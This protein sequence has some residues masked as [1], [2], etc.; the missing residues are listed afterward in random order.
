MKIYYLLRL[1]ALKCDYQDP[2][3]PNL[4]CYHLQK[5]EEDVICSKKERRKLA[6]ASGFEIVES[7]PKKLTKRK[8]SPEPESEIKNGKVLDSGT[9]L[10]NDVVEHFWKEAKLSETFDGKIGPYVIRENEER[11]ENVPPELTLLNVKVD[12]AKLLPLPL[13]IKILDYLENETLLK[14]RQINGSLQM[15]AEIILRRRSIFTHPKTTNKFIATPL[16]FDL[17]PDF[18]AQVTLL[19]PV[20]DPQT[21]LA[22]AAPQTQS[23]TPDDADD[24]DDVDNNTCFRDVLSDVQTR[25]IAIQVRNVYCKPYTR[26]VMVNRLDV[27]RVIHHDSCNLLAVAA[28]PSPIE[29]FSCRTLKKL[30]L[31]LNNRRE[32][33]VRCVHIARRDGVVFTAGHDSVV[34]CWSTANGECTRIFYGHRNSV[35]CLALC[36]SRVAAGSVDGNTKLWNYADRRKCVFTFRD[37]HA[38]SCVALNQYICITGCERGNVRV[39]SALTGAFVKQMNDTESI[40]CVRVNRWL[41][42]SASGHS[43]RMWSTGGKVRTC[44]TQFLH[45][46]KVSQ[47]EVHFFRVITGCRDGKIRVWDVQSGRLLH[48]IYPGAPTTALSPILSFHLAKEW[49][50]VNTEARVVLLNF[51]R[52]AQRVPSNANSAAAATCRRDATTSDNSVNVTLTGHAIRLF[53]SLLTNIKSHPDPNTPPHTSLYHV[54]VEHPSWNLEFAKKMLKSQ[55]QTTP[56]DHRAVPEPFYSIIS[57]LKN[58]APK[59]R[60][61]PKSRSDNRLAD[62][63][64]AKQVTRRAFMM[65]TNDDATIPVSKICRLVKVDEEKTTRSAKCQIKAKKRTKF[66]KPPVYAQLESQQPVRYKRAVKQLFTTTGGECQRAQV[67]MW[68]L[69]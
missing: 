19:V 53:K 13:I 45:P 23:P 28:F 25:G 11:R 22:I 56:T 26:H 12:F 49:I 4:Q 18:V 43:V 63:A 1:Q 38:I 62:P 7:K 64:V 21:C 41:I 61:L 37:D 54:P 44:L 67:H 31:S 69:K 65:R 42:S 50:V 36:G 68:C 59:A 32:S 27:R 60:S 2:T 55:R 39:Y 48:Y 15:A 9:V 17:D 40:A 47:V 16:V 20:I 52:N 5:Q 66:Y 10:Y 57:K 3:S 58:P 29:F 34:R 24:V 30:K 8:S 46:S 6:K 51:D 35:S 33:C 14:C